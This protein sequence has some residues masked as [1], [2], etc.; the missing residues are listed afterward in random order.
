MGWVMI[1][2]NSIRIE[3]DADL[4][5]F[6]GEI[7]GLNGGADFYGSNPEELRQEFKVSLEEFLAVCEEQG[8]SPVKEY[9]GRFNLHISPELHREIA[10]ATAVQ[11]KSINQWVS[12]VLEEA[13]QQ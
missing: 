6:C 11:N 5:L 1:N 4:N 12:D 3:Y 2:E 13:V 7:L 9:S 10:I 8:I